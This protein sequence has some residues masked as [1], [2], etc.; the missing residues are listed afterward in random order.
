MS[1]E[2]NRK[3]GAKRD[4]YTPQ[5]CFECQ[6]RKVKGS[7][8]VRVVIPEVSSAAMPEKINQLC[9]HGRNGLGQCQCT[10]ETAH[11]A[12]PRKRSKT[13]VSLKA[14]LSQLQDQ[15][16]ALSRNR[17]CNGTDAQDLVAMPSDNRIMSDWDQSPNRTSSSVSTDSENDVFEN[18]STGSLT[19]SLDISKRNHQKNP[20]GSASKQPPS[21][22]SLPIGS[23]LNALRK[24]RQPSAVDGLD[25]SSQ[26]LV[27]TVTLPEP[28]RLRGLVNVFFREFETYFPCLNQVSIRERFC[29]VL[30]A[31][32]Y[33][34]AHPQIVIGSDNCKIIAI[35]LS[36]LA[37]AESLTHPVESCKARP[38]SPSYSEGLRLMQHFNQLYDDDVETVIYHIT[39]SAFLLEMSMHHTA[40]Q[41][42]T[43]GFQIALKIG[44]NNQTL[45]PNENTELASRQGLWWTI[46]FL[47]KRI[48]QKCGITYFL[49]EDES[50]VSDFSKATD[51]LGSSKYNLLQSLISFS[52]LW[53]H[54][55]DGFFSPQ[56]PKA[57]DWEEAQMMDTRIILSYRQIPPNLRWK[58][59]MVT[60]YMSGEGETHIRQRLI[61]FLRF[62][63][64][65]L[66]I[67]HMALSSNENDLERRKTSVSICKAIIEAI[68]SY[69]ITTASLKPCGYIMTTALVESLYHILPE[70]GHPAPVVS[71]KLLNEMIHDASQLLQTLS[72]SVA[73]ASVVYQY[74]RDLLP[75]KDCLGPLDGFPTASTMQRAT[76]QPSF[77]NCPTDLEPLS[78]AFWRSLGPQPRQDG[79][80]APTGPEPKDHTCQ[81][82]AM[83][84]PG[85]FVSDCLPFQLDELQSQ[86][87]LDHLDDMA[88]EIPLSL[89]NSTTQ[90]GGDLL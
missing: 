37:Y 70:D 63:S 67:R 73:T 77:L 2:N 25:E 6:R 47:D 52:R 79:S 43:Q 57:D 38:L 1:E 44:L 71:H 78:E 8:Y 46:Y 87:L 9:R 4:K 58:S 89:D 60:E 16:N 49:R 29:M 24:L 11:N 34:D 17:S 65:R 66:S 56:A 90:F 5:A 88:F 75:P 15:V 59:C 31:H 84:P 42:I 76:N 19:S 36:M 69:M 86:F 12:R 53:A 18:R 68:R 54:I 33:G 39:S 26:F 40:L 81:P 51:S 41:S 35:L 83:V 7:L 50:A 10:V 14:Q 30:S 74:L 45:W 21:L 32:G 55:W 48:T 28:T 85:S 27:A 3:E 13:S 82:S 20:I 22:N 72:E 64:L 23:Q 61:V 80:S 62:Q